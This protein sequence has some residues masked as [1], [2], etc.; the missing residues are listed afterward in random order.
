[1]TDRINAPHRTTTGLGYTLRWE[2]ISGETIPA[3]G[4]IQLKD[5]YV[6][7]YSQVSKPDGDVGLFY[8]NG[9][10]DVSSAGAGESRLWNQ[11]REVLIT[12]TP[13]VGDEVGPVNGSWSMSADGHGFRVFRQASGGIGVVTPV[14]GGGGGSVNVIHGIVY[15]CLGDGYYEIEISEWSGLTPDQESSGAGSC[16]ICSLVSP[17]SSSGA[18]CEEDPALPEFVAS[19][20]EEEGSITRQTT[21]TGVIVLA[22][23]SGSRFIPLKVG[24]D[25]LMVDLGDEN[26]TV[27]SEDDSQSSGNM[28]PVY[29]I[30]RGHQE[31]L[32]LY[33]ERWECCAG[34]DTL[35]GRTPIIFPGIECPEEICT[36]CEE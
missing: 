7:P 9:R 22:F 24:T 16:N 6:S 35:M 27:G 10:V 18:N 25:C 36:E 4:V 5:N 34:I 30:V 14:G 3:Y 20:M 33:K 2:N 32:K 13:T 8:V 11:P 17:V 15:S 12:G 28:E 23:D 29:Q 26:P 19:G 31:H 21:E 1:M